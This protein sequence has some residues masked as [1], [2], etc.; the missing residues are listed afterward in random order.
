MENIKREKSFLYS[1]LLPGNGH[2]ILDISKDSRLDKIPSVS[3]HASS[4]H[5]LG[6]LSLSTAD[7]AQNLVELL[8]I[9]LNGIIKSVSDRVC[10]TFDTHVVVEG[11]SGMNKTVWHMALHQS[12]ILM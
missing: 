11:R 6:P 2:A 12:S 8:L 10:Q 5:Q 3:S 7:V 4:T 1:Y 9:Y